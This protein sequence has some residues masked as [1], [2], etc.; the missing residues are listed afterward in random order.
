[1]DSRARSRSASLGE[2]V[3]GIFVA[4]PL[5]ADGR[6]GAMS[7]GVEL[8]PPISGDSA[9]NVIAGVDS[10]LPLPAGVVWP[11]LEDSDEL[12][13]ETGGGP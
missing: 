13:L 8:I 9:V 12:K 1:M 2:T 11:L 6:E 7:V 4:A 3:R 5:C 10:C